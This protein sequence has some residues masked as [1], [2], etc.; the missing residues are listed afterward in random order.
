VNQPE[1]VDTTD[2]HCPLAEVDLGE[3]DYWDGATLPTTIATEAPVLSADRWGIGAWFVG[4]LGTMLA[5]ISAFQGGYQGAVLVTLVT[6]AFETSVLA[7][8]AADRKARSRRAAR[9]GPPVADT[10]V[11][12]LTS[13]I[14]IDTICDEICNAELRAPAGARGMVGH[15]TDL[16]WARLAQLINAENTAVRARNVTDARHARIGLLDLRA[17]TAALR[18]QIQRLS[19]DIQT[20]TTPSPLVI[21]DR[22]THTARF[23][24]ALDLVRG[25][26]DALAEVHEITTDPHR[27]TTRPGITA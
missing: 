23:G 15:A 14:L 19:V 26:A 25:H 6:V 7:Y 3:R 2:D 18:E 10:L 17:E 11:T 21:T 5:A 20:S 13:K 16:L 12:T 4:I 8:A 1:P 27:L 22:E 9:Y 24:A